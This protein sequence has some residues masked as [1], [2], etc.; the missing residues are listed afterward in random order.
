MPG[1]TADLGE[2]LHCRFNLHFRAG[3]FA[4][5]RDRGMIC[6]PLLIEPRHRLRDEARPDVAASTF[7]PPRTS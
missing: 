5:R 6:P 4:K 3:E 1:P 7:P 2:H